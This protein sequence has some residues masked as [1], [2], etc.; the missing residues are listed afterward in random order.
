MKRQRGSGHLYQRGRIWWMQYFVGSERVRESCETEDREQAARTLHRRLGSPQL[1]ATPEKV[2]VGDL[3][4]LL[5]DD[6]EFRKLRSL[7]VVKWRADVHLRPA[8]GQLAAASFT[9][10]DVKRY[11]ERRRAAGAGDATIN[12][13]LSILRRGFT[14][15]MQNDPP[16][17][18]RAP[19]IPKLEEDN[20]RQGFLEPLQYEAVL[21]ELPARL[22]ALFVVAYHVGCR[23]GELLKLR[24][25]QVDFAGHA[26]R[27]TKGQTKGKAA[28][29]LPIYGDMERWLRSQADNRP[30]GC[31]WVFYYRLGPVGSHLDG[32]AEACERAGVEGLLFH[33]LRRSAVRN[34][35]RAGVGDVEAMRISGHKTRAIFDRYKWTKAT[36]LT[37]R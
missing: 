11:V 23:K 3:I 24:W 12:R 8:F 17:I 33:D 18:A 19:H 1:A 7:S 14:L 25:E 37:Q 5:V 2:T 27:L 10:R 29:T 4:D 22:K 6:Y 32:W 31:P 21:T 30:E 20:V 36:S 35:K 9:V 13:E 34:M 16:L 28:Q 26:I 15:A